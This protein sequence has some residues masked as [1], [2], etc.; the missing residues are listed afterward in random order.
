MKPLLKLVAV[1]VLL[2]AGA[3]AVETTLNSLPEIN[4]FPA[5]QALLGPN[6][7]AA[8]AAIVNQQNANNA[9]LR[10]SINLQGAGAPVACG[11][12]CSPSS[13]FVVCATVA[14][15][16]M[17]LPS[18]IGAGNII[19]ERITVATTGGADRVLVNTKTDAITG[20]AVGENASTPIVFWGSANTYHSIQMPFAG[21]KPS[22]GFA[23]DT[24]S[25]TDILFGTWSCDIQFQA[26]TTPTTPYS[27]STN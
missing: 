8:I 15:C 19:R 10:A 22:G 2:A 14:G 16:T 24:I 4:V 23:G 9:S 21:T 1:C 7:V 13:G 26:G 25:C 11:A 5:P 27:A 6:N 18:S 12:A 3:A 20:I 17:T